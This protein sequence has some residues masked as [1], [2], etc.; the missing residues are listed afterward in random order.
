MLMK[1]ELPHSA[2]KKIKTIKL[3][4]VSGDKVILETE[5]EVNEYI[6]KLRDCLIQEIRNN[7]R[8][9]LS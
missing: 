8:V 9:K 3:L 6:D 4:D 7:N 1:E 5:D 2:K